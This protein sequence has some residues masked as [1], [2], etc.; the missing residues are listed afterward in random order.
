MKRRIYAL[1]FFCGFLTVLF[2]YIFSV[3]SFAS[4][5]IVP[6]ADDMRR[7]PYIFSVDSVTGGNTF[8]AASALH[9]YENFA[10]PENQV[11]N[12]KGWFATDEGVSRYEYAW[13]SGL[14]R[15]PEWK[16]AKN[17]SIVP[18]P[19]LAV[20]G[21]PYTAGHGTAGFSFD[22]SPLEGM[23]DGYYDLY[24]RAITGDGVACD[25]VLFSHM[26]YGT[27]DHDDGQIRVVSFPRLAKTE[28]ALTNAS[29]TEA[30]LV[31]TNRSMVALGAVD[32]SEFDR[33]IITYSF[34]QSYEAEKQAILGFKSSSDRLYGDGEGLYDLTH[35]IT[36]M[37]LNTGTT[38][39]QTAEIDLSKVDITAHDGLYLSAYVKDGVALT[40]HSIEFTYR[41]RGYDRTA[42][43]IYFSSDIINHFTGRNLVDLK[44]VQ[45]PV[46]GDV[47]RIE[48][49]DETKDP[50]AHFNAAGVLA[51][52]DLRLNADEYK[53]MV[54]LA[55]AS[56]DNLHST[57]T[58][59]LCAG[60][61]L[62]ATEACT[63]SHQLIKDGQWHYYVFDLTARENWKGNING[64]R[65]DIISGESVPGN[66]VDFATIQF[67]RT[68]EAAAAA[69]GASVKDNV[70]PHTLGLP[71]VVRDDVEETFISDAP[72]TFVDGEW[73]E[74]T[75]VPETEPEPITSPGETDH[76]DPVV[77]L[78]DE[79][80]ETNTTADTQFQ[81]N[82]CRSMVAASSLTFLIPFVFIIKKK[83]S[84]EL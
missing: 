34:S 37:P 51:Q 29:I 83:K 13:V 78:P 33:V 30:G 3:T 27:P 4:E 48:V 24:V 10:L 62:S 26:K 49:I 82:G 41:G 8:S 76:A 11:L 65:F 36:A 38:E 5:N 71:A 31:M 50:Y 67:F 52:D 55:R 1:R 81:E 64:W 21:I 18:R 68:P 57:M 43:K 66:Y 53:Y 22:I 75:T 14:N 59:Y 60:N 42:A 45:D 73:F 58:F 25:I 77:T 61:I 72:A 54:V 63:Y 28:S 74:E 15:V 70:T 6:A 39:P 46:M 19:D 9:V 40:V 47:L 56:K 69:A 23:K 80:G 12:L 17:I 20:V 44:G 32:L 79:N 35:H 16:T 84:E 2:L 7:A